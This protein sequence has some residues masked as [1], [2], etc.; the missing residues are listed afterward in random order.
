MALYAWFPCPLACRI[1][2]ERSSLSVRRGDPRRRQ[3]A[4]GSRANAMNE[5]AVFVILADFEMASRS[6]RSQRGS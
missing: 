3:A 5:R 6:R 1:S 4:V 2:D